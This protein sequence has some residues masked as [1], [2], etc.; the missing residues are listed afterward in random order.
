MSHILA[1][2]VGAGTQDIL[3]HDS[4]KTVENC[5]KLVLP[6]RTVTIGERIAR[7]TKAG[8]PVFLTGNLMG[9]GPLASAAKKHARAGLPIWA[10]PLAAKSIR[11]DPGEVEALGIVI[12]EEPPDDAITIATKDVDLDAI[13]QALALFGV[14]LPAHRAIAV[15]DHGESP[16]ISQRRF[17]FKQWADF[18]KG[19]GKLKDLAYSGNT[20]H[21]LTRMRSVLSDVPNAL[22]MDTSS[23]AVVGAMCDE[24]VAEHTDEGVVIVNVGNQHTLGVL[25]QGDRILGVFEH[26]TVFVD[27]EK[28][29]QLVDRLRAGKIDNDEIYEDKGHGAYV[30]PGYLELRGDPA[31]SFRFVTVTGPNRH[32]AKG[33]GYH[34][35]VPHGD[36]MLSGCFGLVMAARWF[37]WVD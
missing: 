21:Y 25:C 29:Q 13:G 7:A 27:T 26:H 36:M 20:P 1:I 12:G 16:G 24:H 33:L 8:R 19:G 30:D 5:V 9:G 35:A 28:L 23:A 14:P 37:G 34:F 22:L 17:R 10:T 2:D 32:I 3:L 11:D 18:V 4:D 31:S 15:Q 6:S